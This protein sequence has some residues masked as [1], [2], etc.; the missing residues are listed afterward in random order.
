MCLGAAMCL[1]AERHAVVGSETTLGR[2]S[3]KNQYSGET[4]LGWLSCI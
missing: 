2:F 3:C 1:A 4:T